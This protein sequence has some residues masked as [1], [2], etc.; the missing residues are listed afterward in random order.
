MTKDMI[1]TERVTVRTALE[2]L[3]SVALI[4][5]LGF[6]KIGTEQVS[7]YQ[8]ENGTPIYFGGGIFEL[9]L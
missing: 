7:F 5:S 1:R 8:D 4:A 2:N 3:P 6:R 9:I